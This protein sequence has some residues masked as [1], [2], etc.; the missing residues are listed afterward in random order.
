MW[1]D[2]TY[3]IIIWTCGFSYDAGWD[4][5]LPLLPTHS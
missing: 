5:Y 2:I 1:N 3:M 4:R